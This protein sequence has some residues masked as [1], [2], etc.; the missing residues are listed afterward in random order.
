[1]KIV[2]QCS[3]QHLWLNIQL[4]VYKYLKRTLMNVSPA[5]LKTLAIRYRLLEISPTKII[6]ERIQDI[7]LVLLQQKDALLNLFV[8]NIAKKGENQEMISPSKF[9]TIRKFLQIRSN[10]CSIVHCTLACESLHF[11]CK[12]IVKVLFEY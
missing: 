11:D 12:Y 9:P 7:I 3:K 8:S 6:E 1:M 2:V 5:S 10:F 4:F